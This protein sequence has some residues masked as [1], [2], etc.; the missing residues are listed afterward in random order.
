MHEGVVPCT[1]NC[2]DPEPE[3]LDIVLGEPREVD[4]RIAMSNSFGFGGHNITL[5]IRRFEG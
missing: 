3:G 5:I 4:V 2:E 1:L